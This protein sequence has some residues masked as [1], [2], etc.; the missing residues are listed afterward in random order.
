MQSDATVRDDA[1]IATPRRPAPLLDIPGYVILCE[2]GRGGMGV[3]YKA[4]QSSLGREVALKVLPSTLATLRSDAVER[5]RR[6]AS[7]ASKLHHHHIIPVYDFGT[8]H[9]AYYY[10]MELASGQ[11]LDVLIKRLGAQNVTT[12]SPTQLAEVLSTGT[13]STGDGDASAD[14]SSALSGS[15]STARGRV[16]YRQVARWMADI[17]DALH[18]AHGQGVI[19]RDIKPGN[20]IIKLD[21]RI[22]LADF[23]LA[24][25]ADTESVT[26][27]GSLI[28]TWRYMSPEQALAK[29][30]PLDHRTDIYSLGATMYEMLVFQP[31]IQGRDEKEIITQI[32]TKEPTRPR[33]INPSVPRELETICLK[34]LEKA[35]D[36]RYATAQEL[37]DDLRRYVDDLPIVAR[38]P[39]FVGRTAKFLRRHSAEV[40]TAAGVVA[41]VAILLGGFVGFR[42]HLGNSHYQRAVQSMVAGDDDAAAESLLRAYELGNKRAKSAL[43][44]SFAKGLLSRPALLDRE[45]A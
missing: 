29:R 9:G 4:I 5:F 14:D 31:A 33:R 3:V 21:G 12:I 2:I 26:V 32:I 19:H 23:G 10:A 38:R 36:A 27:T 17:A 18:Y 15:T 37:A 44:D 40:K 13:P 45:A 39:G 16:Y 28:G 7:A 43:A 1:T 25:V 41:V 24:K 6:E 30:M 34:T 8:A 22:V 20:L 42:W 35:P 11:P